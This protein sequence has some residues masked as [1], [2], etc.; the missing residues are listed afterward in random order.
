MPM[1]EIT[2]YESGIFRYKYKV[3]AEDQDEAEK[4]VIDQDGN[5][6]AEF[7]ESYCTADKINIHQ[8]KQIED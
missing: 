4:F 3:E 6:E 8:S 2:T 1:F 5:Y 7:I